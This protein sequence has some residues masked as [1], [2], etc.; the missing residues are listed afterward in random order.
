MACELCQKGP[1]LVGQHWPRSCL[2][3]NPRCEVLSSPPRACA[4]AVACVGMSDASVVAI[5]MDQM[6]P[7]H[8]GACGAKGPSL[9]PCLTRRHLSHAG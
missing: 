9:P 6:E 1:P 3:R 2:R 7:L 4:S 8:P 5:Q